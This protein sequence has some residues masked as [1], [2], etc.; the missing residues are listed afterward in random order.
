MILKFLKIIGI[1]LILSV[2]TLANATLIDNGDFTSDTESGLD[3]L[4]WTKTL[5]YTQSEALDEYSVAG[6][7]IATEAEAKGLI[8]NHFMYTMLDKNG[9]VLTDSI[10]DFSMKHV[11]FATLFGTTILNPNFN[12]AEGS[13][14]T[15]EGVGYFGSENARNHLRNGDFP[16]SQG[17]VG[18]RS[19]TSGVAL[20]QVT[21]V[22]EPSIIALFGLGLVGIGFARRR[23][24]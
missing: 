10:N 5:N 24:S 14:A 17:A 11:Q 20:V 23:Q 21:D 4:D 7:R 16:T 13:H 6:W 12:T 18:L 19:S 3:W 15:I 2:S 1:G 9:F 22:S 8:L